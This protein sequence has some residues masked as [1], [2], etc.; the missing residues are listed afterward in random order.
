MQEKISIVFL[1]YAFKISQCECCCRKPVL[2]RAAEAAMS[3][4]VQR[5]PLPPAL[6]QRVLQ[7]LQQ[8]QQ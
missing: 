7:S 8:Q 1:G 4:P 5:V 6:W 3:V 2:V